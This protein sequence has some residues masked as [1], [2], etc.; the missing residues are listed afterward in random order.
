MSKLGQLLNQETLVLH[1]PLLTEKAAP[2][3]VHIFAVAKNANK[4]LIRAAI[5][6]LYQ[7][8]PRRVNIVNVVGKKIV[9]RGKTGNRPGMKK[10]IVYL[11]TGD[12]I[13]LA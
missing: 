3:G 6:R 9:V 2:A 13:N 10:A 11:K 1:R 5:K 12:K 7:V 4:P 8:T